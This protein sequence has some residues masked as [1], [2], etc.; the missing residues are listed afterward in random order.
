MQK[1]FR[2]IVV[3]SLTIFSAVALNIYTAKAE[4]YIAPDAVQ[5]TT[6]TYRPEYAEFTQNLGTYNY[7]TSWE[8]IPAASLTAKVEQEGLNYRVTVT[9]KTCKMID[10]F[11]KLRYRAEG[12][13]STVDFSP[14]K[15][16]F[17]QKENSRD[18]YVEINFHPHGEVEAI[19]IDREKDEVKTLKFDPNNFMLDPFS[20]A[21]L[22]RSLN[23]EKG[24]S[25]EFDTFNGKS[26]YLITLK[27]EDQVK[28]AVNGEMR[29]VWVISPTV[30]NLSYPEQNSKLRKAEIYV[31]A[32]KH[33]EILKIVSSVF[34]GSVT[35]KLVSFESSTNPTPPTSVAKSSSVGFF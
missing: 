20:A 11:Y 13:M 30:K 2:T 10:L 6:P 21:F 27:A 19:R 33:R 28:I 22:A 32:D 34:V 18:R 3:F 31:T 9:A 17:E 29:D 16:T 14:I 8:G 35:T 5:I 12:L 1:Y 24:A 7:S 23:W 4:D 25:R 15:D 26:R